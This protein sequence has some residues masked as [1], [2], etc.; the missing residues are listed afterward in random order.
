MPF[1]R[2]VNQAATATRSA[3]ALLRG[4]RTADEGIRR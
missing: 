2:A 4:R 1:L 3:G